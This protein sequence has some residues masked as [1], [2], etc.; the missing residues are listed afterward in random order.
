MILLG[1]LTLSGLVASLCM[2][3]LLPRAEL[4]RIA[5]S[6]APGTIAA[7]AFVVTIVT[8]VHLTL[9]AHAQA[10]LAASSPAPPV[11]AVPAPTVADD[12]VQRIRRVTREI[13]RIGGADYL[14]GT[15]AAAD[16]IRARAAAI[17]AERRDEARAIVAAGFDGVRA[18]VPDFLDWYYS[19]GGEYVRIFKT[20]AGDGEAY[21]EERMAATLGT[22]AAEETI[23]RDLAAISGEAASARAQAAA[24]LAGLLEA[25]RVVL[26]ARDVGVVVAQR[27][28]DPSADLRG[29]ATSVEW[30]LGSAGATGATAGVVGALAVKK[31]AAKGIFRTAGKM[32]A[33][34]AIS[35]GAAGTGGAAMGALAGG[36]AGSVVPRVGT[37]IGA[38]IGGVLG[39][40]GVTR[41]TDGVM[42]GI[43]EYFG[44]DD[45]EARI[46]AAIDEAERDALLGPGLA[47]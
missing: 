19:L 26:T 38:A 10:A 7:M 14:P 25:N 9:V 18:K 1:H 17:D 39:A 21:F 8:A 30:R 45:F 27:V 43:E 20:L 37:V 41:S 34:A 23:D 36:A 32:A 42:L 12:V 4:S 16:A 2:V 22:D 11:A 44:R 31:I 15:I 46:M 47:D 28:T 13:E 35:K 24:D 6:R 40:V 33:K 5:G 29:T 3:L